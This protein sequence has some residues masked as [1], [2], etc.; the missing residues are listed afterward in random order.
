MGQQVRNAVAARVEVEF[1]R[2][3]EGIECLVQ[4]DRAAVN[5]K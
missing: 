5:T 3:L 4:F 2:N 1:V